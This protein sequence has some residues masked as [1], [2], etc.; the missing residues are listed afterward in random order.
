MHTPFDPNPEQQRIERT[1]Q[2]PVQVIGRFLDRFDRACDGA[3][4][5]SLLMLLVSLVAGLVAL[6][7][8]EACG[9]DVVSHLPGRV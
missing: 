6:L 7:V 5:A 9:V 3:A 2:R 4:M 1:C 8:L